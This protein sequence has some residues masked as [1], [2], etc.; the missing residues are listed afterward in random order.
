MLF[1]I[2]NPDIQIWFSKFSSRWKG[3]LR[4]TGDL[5]SK[6]CKLGWEQTSHQ[7]AD[8]YHYLSSVTESAHWMTVVFIL[9]FKKSQHRST[10]DR[11]NKKS[12]STLLK[13]SPFPSD[14]CGL[15][16]N[17]LLQSSARG[18]NLLSIKTSHFWYYVVDSRTTI[19]STCDR[20]NE[21][22]TG[23]PLN[24]SPCPSNKSD[25][26]PSPSLQ[27]KGETLRFLLL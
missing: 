23:T 6:N 24:A 2:T 3:H 13:S 25:M 10:C 14:K 27:Y 12:I 19:I 18:K 20:I 17:S 7:T 8:S 15:V 9:F 16:F 21:K 26:I 4:E 22:S 5:L 11:M 1:F